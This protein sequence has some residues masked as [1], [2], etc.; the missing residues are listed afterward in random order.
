MTITGLI[1]MRLP[2]L[3]PS[4]RVHLPVTTPPVGTTVNFIPCPSPFCIT[5]GFLLHP[6]GSLQNTMQLLSCQAGLTSSPP[7]HPT[8]ITSNLLKNKNLA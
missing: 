1:K 2:R 3:L 7:I 5:A 4:P 8:E 6:E